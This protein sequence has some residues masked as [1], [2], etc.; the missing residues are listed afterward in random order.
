MPHG[1]F[2]IIRIKYSDG[3]D[4]GDLYALLGVARS[5]SPADLRRG[6]R[7]QA[8]RWHPDRNSDRAAQ[9][10]MAAINNAFLTL[11][12]ATTRRKYDETL[13]SAPQADYSGAPTHSAPRSAARA[14]GGKP[15]QDSPTGQLATPAGT[16]KLAADLRAQGFSVVD[17]RTRGGVL[18]VV[19]RPELEVV[20]DDLCDQGIEFEYASNGGMATQ[21]K[22]AWW[23]RAWG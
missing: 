8:K 15:Q 2:R 13:R 23:T 3:V 7:L 17:N 18:W 9:A 14:S 11:S 4:G 20:L 5:S 22:P 19:D 16:V 6:R 21:Y 10:R 1:A 12:D